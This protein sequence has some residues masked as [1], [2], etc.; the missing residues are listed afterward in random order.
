MVLLQVKC[1]CWWRG[2]VRK[3]VCLLKLEGT[4]YAITITETRHMY[5]KP[6]NV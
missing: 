5:R 2:S 6:P 4:T 1:T 3:C